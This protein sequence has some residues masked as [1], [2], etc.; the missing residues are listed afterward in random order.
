MITNFGKNRRKR[1][2]HKFG[3]SYGHLS[4]CVYCLQ[5]AVQITV[6]GPPLHLSLSLNF[7]NIFI[8][9]ANN[10]FSIFKLSIETSVQ[11][12]GHNLLPEDGSSNIREWR[13]HCCKTVFPKGNIFKQRISLNLE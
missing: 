9:Y 2:W 5:N 1:Y 12:G 6:I 4:L 3:A 8:S 10:Y 7:T 13:Q 11:L